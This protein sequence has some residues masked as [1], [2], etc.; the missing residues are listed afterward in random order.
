MPGE[1]GSY[2]YKRDHSGIII[3]Y[4][5]ISTVCYSLDVVH[6]TKNCYI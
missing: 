5:G 2:C 6:P 1:R 4:F 3:R